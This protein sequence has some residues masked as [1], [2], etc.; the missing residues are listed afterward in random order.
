MHMRLKKW[1]RAELSACPYRLT[2]N[3]DLKGRWRGRFANPDAPL[4]LEIGCGKGVY[5]S[6]LA[7]ARPDLNIIAMD[8][9]PEVLGDTRRN[10]AALCGEPPANALILQADACRIEDYFD[11][12]DRVSAI[13]LNFSNP[14]SKHPKHAKRRLT[15]PR[16]LVQYRRFLADG[17]EIRFKTDD[18]GF[19]D[20]SRAYFLLCGFSP[21]YATRSLHAPG[22]PEEYRRFVSEHEKKFMANGVPILFCVFRKTPEPIEIS[23]LRFRLTPGVRKAALERLNTEKSA[24]PDEG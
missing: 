7:A 13:L 14:W 5:T 18:P 3:D 16:Q 4:V 15:H 2:E 22:T 21:V 19:F 23:P 10:L 17:G 12:T 9:S 6:R 11:E 24:P 1:A 8:M 20:D